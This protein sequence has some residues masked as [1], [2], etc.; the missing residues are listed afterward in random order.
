MVLLERLA[1]EGVTSEED[2]QMSLERVTIGELTMAAALHVSSSLTTSE[3]RLQVVCD[4]MVSHYP[5][6]IKVLVL[7]E[8]LDIIVEVDEELADELRGEGGR[9]GRGDGVEFGCCRGSET[10]GSHSGYSC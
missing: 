1:E 9:L 6:E 2:L 7:L 8:C 10:C 4:P 3:K 5:L